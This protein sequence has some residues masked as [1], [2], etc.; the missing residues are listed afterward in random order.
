MR[1]LLLKF[2]A[3]AVGNAEIVSKLLRSFELAYLKQLRNKIDDITMFMTAKAKICLI[4]ELQAGILIVMKRT[5]G[6]SAAVDL[7]SVKFRG[8]TCGDTGFDRLKNVLFRY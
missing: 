5:T 1:S 6:H 4:I 2:A 8:G 3:V 7:D